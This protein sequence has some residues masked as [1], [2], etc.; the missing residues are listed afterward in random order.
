M[1]TRL[2]MR[3]VD[4]L[5]HP[6]ELAH[7]HNN[8]H[9]YF[10]QLAASCSTHI[11]IKEQRHIARCKRTQRKNSIRLGPPFPDCKLLAGAQH[12]PFLLHSL[13]ITLLC[14]LHR[15]LVARNLMDQ[16]QQRA[17]PRQR[18]GTRTAHAQFLRAI[19]ITDGGGA[20]LSSAT[21]ATQCGDRH[22]LEQ[23]LA[24]AARPETARGARADAGKARTKRRR[25]EARA[26]G[27]EAAEAAGSEAAAGEQ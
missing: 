23:G 5:A 11:F 9:A 15:F 16:R 27:R 26:R 22:R 12:A 1:S 13:L 3:H 6:F 21:T 4:A 19:G 8:M 18:R 25:R 2:V 10:M 20:L 7:M 24:G 17:Q 14:N